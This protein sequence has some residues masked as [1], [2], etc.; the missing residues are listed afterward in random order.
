[1]NSYPVDYHIHY[2]LDSCAGPDM[3]CTNI[4]QGAYV[5][6]LKEIGVVKHCSEELPGGKDFV[7][8]H[9]LKEEDF[10]TF[11]D[12][13]RVFSPESRIPMYAGVESELID[14]SGKISITG[15]HYDAIDYIMLSVHYMPFL[16]CVGYQPL[17]HP[18][19]QRSKI[20]EDPFLC[21][22][23]L[24]WMDVVSRVGS[25]SIIE[26]LING[27]CNAIKKNKKI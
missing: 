5:L 11:F 23:Y 1:M 27:Y 13:I 14:E 10:Q 24:K 18:R 26:G 22:E 12:D 7:F 6:G 19:A 2:H 16:H 20:Q 9:I 8:W 4:E 15:S 17:I 21:Q 25:M 3:T